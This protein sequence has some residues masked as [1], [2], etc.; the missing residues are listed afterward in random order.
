MDANRISMAPPPPAARTAEPVAQQPAAGLAP[1]R[2]RIAASRIA[3]MPL[4]RT[5]DAQPSAAAGLRR[6]QGAGRPRVTVRQLPA[7]LAPPKD[8]K[9]DTGPPVRVLLRPVQS[10]LLA[11]IQ[12]APSATPQDR[13]RIMK[14]LL[15]PGMLTA[16]SAR[17]LIPALARKLGLAR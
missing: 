15:A 12:A 3:P 17:T 11:R 9:A 10:Q 8:G 2:V 16:E 14:S 4:R 7:N 5:L 1:Q 13:A 6:S